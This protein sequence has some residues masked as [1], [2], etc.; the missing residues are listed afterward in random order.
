MGLDLLEFTLALEEAFQIAIPDADAA[1]IFTPGQVVDYVFARLGGDG[2]PRCLEQVAFY[3]LRR[4]STRV[5]QVGRSTVTPATPWTAILPARDRRRNWRLLGQA[6]GVAPWPPLTLWGRIPSGNE[7]VGATALHLA[8]HA[9][10]AL[11]GSAS[12]TREQVQDA[13]ARLIDE[14]LRVT[15]FSWDQRFLDLGID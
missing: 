4:A 15:Q 9:P 6:A 1:C 5:F 12:W 7:T 13:V 2:A 3:R 11:R 8:K 10:A 14:E